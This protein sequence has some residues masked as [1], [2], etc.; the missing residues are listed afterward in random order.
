ML[1]AVIRAT[2][3]P[4]REGGAAFWLAC[5]IFLVSFLESADCAD[6]N[7]CIHAFCIENMCVLRTNP[8]GDPP[9]LLGR[10]QKFDR[11][12][13]LQRMITSVFELQR[14]VFIVV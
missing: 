4:G 14:Q 9:A 12:G 8:L 2:L 7:G 1:D 10:Q 3:Q 5:F 11:S 13:S 6:K